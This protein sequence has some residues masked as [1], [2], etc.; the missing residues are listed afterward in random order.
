MIIDNRINEEES[1]IYW[2]VDVAPFYGE[3]A[4]GQL[5]E[6]KWSFIQYTNKEDWMADMET[7]G[8][9]YEE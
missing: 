1:T 8:I 9:K 5:T 6:G 2:I 7:L 3:T 4:F